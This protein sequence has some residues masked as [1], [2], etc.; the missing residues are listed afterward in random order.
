M[1]SEVCVLNEEPQKEYDLYSEFITG[2]KIS[3]KELDPIRL[4]LREIEGSVLLTAEEEVFYSRKALKGDMDSR[5]KMIE[6]NLRL[7]V[8]IASRYQNRGLQLLDL[9]EEGN[10]GL[11]RAVEKFDP[12]KG[13]RFSTYATW[14][15]RQ[16]IER[17]L[18]NQ[19]RTIRLPVH[20]IKE[21]N[22]YI[23]AGCELEKN[24]DVE[25]GAEDIAKHL[26]KPVETVE[27]LLKLK[28]DTLSLD[29]SAEDGE[30]G[31]IY[32]YIEDE[33]VIMPDLLIE[34]TDVKSVI[35]VF[36]DHL[37]ERQARVICLRF[38]ID[39]EIHTLEDVAKLL[40][41]TRENI[42]QI[43]VRALKRLRYLLNYYGY[44][45]DYF[46]KE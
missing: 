19:V 5:E 26:D 20:V 38:G 44:N 1:N 36:L 6:C 17:A 21:M 42:R 3:R 4:Y 18:V 24:I 22:V 23:R 29:F 35:Y 33:S 43:Q 11:I 8:K 39:C 9:I 40:G 34:E 28:K 7:V 27:K 2:D 30:D 31:F 41:V 13:F 15:I 45:P 16:T 14:W 25:P 32:E 46:F 37:K 10:L 12:E